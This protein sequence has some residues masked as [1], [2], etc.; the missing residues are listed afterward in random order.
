MIASRLSRGLAAV[1]ALRLLASLI[2]D[3]EYPLDSRTGATQLAM[4][5]ALTVLAYIGWPRIRGEG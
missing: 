3:G 4:A 1:M 2:R 5:V